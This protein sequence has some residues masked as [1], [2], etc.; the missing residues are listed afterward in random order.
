ML[1]NFLLVA[2]SETIPADR[3]ALCSCFSEN[4]P[5]DGG[6]SK[7]T[8]FLSS[9]ICNPCRA[10]DITIALL[11]LLIAVPFENQNGVSVENQ[12]LSAL[13]LNLYRFWLKA[14]PCVCMCVSHWRSM[15]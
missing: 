12:L 14:L 3:D 6:Q 1:V 10:F 7:C 4:R 13:G 11:V 5:G 8:I 9:A 15:T 2:C